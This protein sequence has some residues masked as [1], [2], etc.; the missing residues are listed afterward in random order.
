MPNLDALDTAIAVVIV[1]LLLSLIV[2]SVQAIFKKLLKIKSRQLEQSL[3]DLFEHIIANPQTSAAANS[4]AGRASLTM[5]KSPILQLL[6]PRSKHASEL[7]G[8]DVKELYQAV[9]TRFK[10][11]GRVSMAGKAMLDSISKEDLIK[12]LRSVA[13][14]S[15]LPNLVPELTAACDRVNALNTAL[16]DIDVNQLDGEASAKFAA[17]YDALAPAL[18]DM[19][20]I[21]DGAKLNP[22][23]LLGDVMALRQI[24]LEEV[25][26]LLGEVQSKVEEDIKAASGNQVRLQ[27]LD[28][29]A[30]VLKTVAAIMIEVRQKFDM[31]LAPVRI[32]LAEVESGYDT[33]MQS[34][35]ERYARSMKTWAVVISFLV[36]VFLNANFFNIY[37]NISANDVTRNLIVQAGPEVLGRADAAAKVQNPQS[38]PTA[39]QVDQN[40]KEL[41]ASIQKVRGQLRSDVDTYASLGFAPSKWADFR[42]WLTTLPPNDFWLDHR[43]ADLRTLLGWIITAL[44]LSVGAPFWQDMLESLFGIKSLLRKRGEIRNVE[45][46]S[47]AGQPKP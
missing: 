27:V 21:M 2:Q 9:V 24:K 7:A 15:L 47:G 22:K 1:L 40:T 38:P 16:L 13:P 33:V 29:V 35:D 10:E 3:V 30:Q 19:R 39:D 42:F 44:L 32:K 18:S 31:A 20:S 46:A 8:K 37:K 5:R 41:L 6:V 34:F 45:T 11:I 12:V 25:L 17:M 4:L 23:L 28:K 43:K 14:G 36:V 26:K